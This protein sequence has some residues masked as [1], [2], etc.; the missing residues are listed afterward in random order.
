MAATLRWNLMI[1]AIL[2]SVSLVDGV[3]KFGAAVRG[4]LLSAAASHVV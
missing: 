4:A 1:G 2:S 3:D